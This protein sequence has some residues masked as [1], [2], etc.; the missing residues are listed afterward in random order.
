M[1]EISRDFSTAALIASIT[2]NLFE[3]FEYLGR[4]AAAEFH[5]DPCLK[6]V[7]TG[8][9]NSF[10]NNIYSTRLSSGQRG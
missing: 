6:W 7:F 9:P 4:S 5:V 3:Y 1:N 8:I 10:M 2:A